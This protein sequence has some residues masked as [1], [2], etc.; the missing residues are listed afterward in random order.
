MVGKHM[1][2][3]TQHHPHIET[4]T[5]KKAKAAYGGTAKNVPYTDGGTLQD[6]III[7]NDIL[8]Q[9]AKMGQR[10]DV[11]MTCCSLNSE[12]RDRLTKQVTSLPFG[13]AVRKVVEA[14]GNCSILL[15][16]D[17]ERDRPFS[18]S[19]AKLLFDQWE[20]R[21]PVGAGKLTIRATGYL[22][23]L[24]Q[25][26]MHFVVATDVSQKQWYLRVEK[27]HPPETLKGFRLDAELPA[28]VAWN[29]PDAK[30]YGMKLTQG[31]ERVFKAAGIRARRQQPDGIFFIPEP[32]FV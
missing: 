14:G 16:N 28:A 13:D 8:S 11:W 30:E 5:R 6:A 1:A 31:F 23:E 32:S 12:L 29:D 22:P 21:L 15:W 20:G 26:I 10:A 2:T 9:A 25:K 3:M 19:L 7:T 18:P 4:V 24:T 27:P 17:L